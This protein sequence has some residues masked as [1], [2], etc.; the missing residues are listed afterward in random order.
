M[1]AQMRGVDAALRAILHDRDAGVEAGACERDRIAFAFVDDQ[2]D[3]VQQRGAARRA[4][5]ARFH[6]SP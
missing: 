1:R 4:L 5:R 3:A 6:A 2:I